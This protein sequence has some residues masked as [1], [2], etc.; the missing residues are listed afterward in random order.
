MSAVQIKI[1]YPVEQDFSIVR[2]A[3]E[4][5]D[6]ILD[7]L[8]HEFNHGSQHECKELLERKHCRSLSTNDFVCIGSQW[9]QCASVGWEPVTP[10]YV[11]DIEQK[12]RQH[13]EYKDNPWVAL[14]RVM[15]NK[16]HEVD[17]GY[18]GHQAT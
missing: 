1:K 5:P 12:T 16:R 13:P 11:E 8:F 15:F 4:P 18:P 9:Y 6:A 7:Q 14:D 17:L 10:Q 2:T 3:T